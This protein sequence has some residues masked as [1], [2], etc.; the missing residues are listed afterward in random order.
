MTA[1]QSRT[2]AQRAEDLAREFLSRVWRGEDNDLDAI[3]ELM[4]ED[5]QIHSAMRTIAGRAAFKDWV[6]GFQGVLAGA[7]ND[8]LE[9]FATEA[10]DRVV[11][12][13][14]CSGSNNGIFGLPADGREVAFTGIAIWRVE[15]GRLAEC[16]AERAALEA[17]QALT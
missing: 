7:R 6:A 1:A 16:W 10:G 9:V 11:A 3:D 17:W 13:W 8:I 4:T 2:P 14:R 15:D 5:Y 12:R